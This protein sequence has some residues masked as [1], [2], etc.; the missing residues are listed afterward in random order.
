RGG[1]R[2]GVL[3]RRQ[4][5][6]DHRRAAGG[7]ARQRRDRAVA[8]HRAQQPVLEHEPRRSDVEP[9]GRDLPVRALALPGLAEARL[10][11]GADH[12]IHRDRDQ[13]R[14]ARPGLIEKTVMNVASVAVPTVTHAPIS[15][16]GLTDKV[17][18]RNLDFYY[19]DAKALKNINISLYQGRVTA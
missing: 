19:G 7:G 13:Y 18:I 6:H 10:D 9:A 8:V 14:G 2:Q 3:P 4:G 1:D 15:T 17:S 11:R 16:A 5:R 12:H